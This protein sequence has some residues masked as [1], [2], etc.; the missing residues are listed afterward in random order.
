MN[1]YYESTVL[2]AGNEAGDMVEGGV[3]ILYADPIPDAL[4]SVSVV[5]GPARGP[6]REIRPGDV[7]SLGEQ[8]VELVAVGERAH[9]NLRTLGHIVVYLN[10]DEGTSLLPGAVHGRGTVT[11]PEAGAR[12]ALSGAAS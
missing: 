8:R 1:V 3:V 10:P 9:E 6:E 11:V 12:L 4:E 2:R 7:F 5:H